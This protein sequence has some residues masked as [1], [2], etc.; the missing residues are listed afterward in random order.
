MQLGQQYDVDVDSA[1]A[2]NQCVSVSGHK[3]INSSLVDGICVAG[4]AECN[5]YTLRKS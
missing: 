2:C 1:E 3:L 5:K 4:A